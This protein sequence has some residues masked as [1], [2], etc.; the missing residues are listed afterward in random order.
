MYFAEDP[1]A[2]S[3]ALLDLTRAARNIRT[4]FALVGGQALQSYGVPRTTQDADALVTRDD[5]EAL[6][7]ELVDRFGWTPL[8]YD[9]DADGYV[10][11]ERPVVLLMNDPVLFD[12]HEEREMIAFETPL[13][14]TVELLAAQHPVEIEMVDQAV[15]RVHHSVRVP[16]APLGGV[17]LIK[18]K[19]NRNKDTAA[20]EQTVEHLPVDQIESAVAWANAHDPATA[21]DLQ[22]LVQGVRI[23][24]KPNGR[25]PR[26]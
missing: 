1:A 17:L 6:A 23:R 19:A 14:L 9:E 16:V 5:L 15:L 18:T 3:S 25:R 11:C 13:R 7:D 21:E 24:R 2:V 26:R 10:A 8:D 4:E 20:I 12:I 22:A